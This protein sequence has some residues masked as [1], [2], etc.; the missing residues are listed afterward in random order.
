MRRG[1]KHYKTINGTLKFFNKTETFFPQQVFTAFVYS[2]GHIKTNLNQAIQ[3]F[4]ENTCLR[5][6]PYDGTQ[7][8]Y[9][10][11]DDDYG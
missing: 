1:T 8:N 7:P 11:F 9:I 10:L 6:V 3:N 2:S 5:F 4:Q